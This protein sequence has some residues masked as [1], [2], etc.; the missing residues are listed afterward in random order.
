MKS[1]PHFKKRKVI[2]I[3]PHKCTGCHSCEMACSLHHF[4]KC[5]PNYSRIRIQEFR[6]TNTFIPV[7]C[8]GCDDAVCTKY[9][10]VNARTRLENGAVVTDEE[11]CIG[12]RACVAGCQFGAAV[13][14]PES[15]KP[16]SCDLC[17]L[18]ENG[19][20]CVKACTMQKA[21][22]YV[23]ADECSK[24]KS[25]EWARVVQKDYAPPGVNAGAEILKKAGYGLAEDEKQ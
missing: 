15:K 3:D 8:Q 23:N 25:R 22:R 7:V 12:C 20:A 21:L 24:M 10:P 17:A 14:N 4:K 11:R 2:M 6:D 5:A 16:M 18:S 19:P 13:V 1:Q 9:C